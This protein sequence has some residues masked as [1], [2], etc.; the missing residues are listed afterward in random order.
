MMSAIRPFWVVEAFFDGDQHYFCAGGR[1][2]GCRDDWATDI[3]WATKFYD[4]HSASQ[5]LFHLCKGNGRCA[6]YSIWPGSSAPVEVAA[7]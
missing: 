3:E 2:R 5:A 6:Q 7:R 1:G 4:E